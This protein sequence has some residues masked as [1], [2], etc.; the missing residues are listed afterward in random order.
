[1]IV[2]LERRRRSLVPAPGCFNPGYKT[3]ETRLTLKAL[4]RSALA[5]PFSV[6]KISSFDPRVAKPTP[7]LELANAFGVTTSLLD[8][9]A[10]GVDSPYLTMI[11]GVLL[12]RPPITTVSW[13]TPAFFNSGINLTLIW[14]R[15]GITPC[16]PAN[17]TGK[18]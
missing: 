13:T 4:A 16:E 7:G 1:M 18:L 9:D 15:P 12:R 6:R 11:V 8:E 17:S 14:S 2:S 10:F 3:E 5:N